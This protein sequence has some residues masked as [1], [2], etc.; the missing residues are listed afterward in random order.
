[1][2]LILLKR[3]LVNQKRSMAV[4]TAAV[5]VGAALAASLLTLSLDISA[6]VSRELRSFGANIVVLP[7]VAGLA[8]LGGQKRYLRE[9]DLPKAKTIFWRHNIVG[10]AP[11][12]IARDEQQGLTLLGTWRRKDLPVPGEQRPFP[13]GVETAMPWWDID[14]AW[15]DKENEVLAGASLARQR[16]LASG[17][18]LSFRGKR[19]T[20]TGLLTTGGRE[21]EMLVAELGA[22]QKLAGLPGKVSQ[23]FVSALT[24]PM[25][26]FAYKDPKTMTAKEYDKWYCTGYVTSIAGQLEDDRIFAGAVARPVWPVAEAEGRLLTRLNLLVYLLAAL[27]LLSSALSVSATMVMS[28]LRRSEE[29]ALMKAMGADGV[30]TVTVFLSEALLIGLAGGV[31]GYLLSL[32]VSGYVGRAVFGTALEERAVLLPASVGASV[33]IAL[34]GAYLPIRRALAIKPA[35]ALKGGR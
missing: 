9:A 19:L 7:K 23:V 21:D 20:V 24:T 16:G 12:L 6:K 31:M 34:L 18:V 13:A 11:V 14:G 3:S 10:L 22:V 29:V 27:V 4:M 5:A 15:P 32:G 35:P 30:K 1:M 25:E 33:L 17:D 8:A 2:L 28:L 26:D